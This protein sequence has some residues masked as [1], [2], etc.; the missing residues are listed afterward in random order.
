MC[1]AIL[2]VKYRND[3]GNPEK[4]IQ[5]DSEAEMVAKIR[6]VQTRPEATQI[7]VFVHNPHASVQLIQEWRTRGTVPRSVSDA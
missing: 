7:D 3:S 6:D 4:P 1:Y 5:C 2:I